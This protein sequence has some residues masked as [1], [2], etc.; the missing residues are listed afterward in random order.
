VITNVEAVFFDLDDTLWAVAPVIL[1]AERKIYAHL[2]EH[3]PRLT[4]AM[5]L[6][7][8]RKTR[9]QIYASRPDLAHDLTT[10]GAWHLSRCCQISITTRRRLLH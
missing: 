2:Q 7:A 1:R 3:F 5:D 4:D 9:S 10:S 6:E 8:I